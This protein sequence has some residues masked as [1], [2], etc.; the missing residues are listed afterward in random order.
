MYL[1]L[2]IAP[3]RLDFLKPLVAGLLSAGVAFVLAKYALPGHELLP[4]LALAAVFALG[5]LGILLLLGIDRE[6]RIVLDRL[7]AKLLGVR[8]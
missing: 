2:H 6:D 4:S 7:K 1:L 8:P 3:Y 5:Y